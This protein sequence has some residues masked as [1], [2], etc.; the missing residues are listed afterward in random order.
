MAKVIRKAWRAIKRQLPRRRRSSH[1]GFE[2]LEWAGYLGDDFEP[3]DK[4]E[5]GT[6]KG[7][8]GWMLESNIK[9]VYPVA[10]TK[11]LERHHRCSDG[12]ASQKSSYC[13]AET[14]RV[15]TPIEQ[16]SARRAWLRCTAEHFATIATPN[17]VG[18]LPAPL[19]NVI[20]AGFKVHDRLLSPITGE[21]LESSLQLCISAWHWSS[22]G[23]DLVHVM[24][25]DY[26]MQHAWLR[27]LQTVG[28][29]ALSLAVA[30][31]LS[32]LQRILGKLTRESETLTPIYN[33]L[34]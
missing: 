30:G 26:T 5:Q 31:V 18:P 4:C 15:T 32:L 11:V 13:D 23:L 16:L 12:A 25:M 1:H 27:E 29:R 28:S 6:C 8:D 34:F 21:V 24:I 9:P 19:L 10:A 14:S 22:F 3:C 33:I 7:H 2:D 17:M 20:R